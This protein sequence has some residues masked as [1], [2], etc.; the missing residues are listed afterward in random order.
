MDNELKKGG[1]SSDSKFHMISN[2]LN[3]LEAEGGR[4]GPVTNILGE[5]GIYLPRMS[6]NE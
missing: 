2:L 1:E 5:M 6:K 4:P 3:S